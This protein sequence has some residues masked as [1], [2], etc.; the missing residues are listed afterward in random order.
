MCCNKPKPKALPQQQA[1]KS[2]RG[3][4]SNPNPPPI[5]VGSEGTVLIEYLLS[6]AGTVTYRG[7]FTKQEYAFGGKRKQNYVDARDAPAL[8]A[9]IEDRRHAFAL[10]QTEQPV[11]EPEKPLSVKEIITEPIKNAV[12]LNE[13][14][15]PEKKRGRPKRV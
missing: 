13:Q 3:I 8:L 11:V 14:S 7:S 2:S 4:K 10:A 12:V 5:V 9:R 15:V 6:K 1:S